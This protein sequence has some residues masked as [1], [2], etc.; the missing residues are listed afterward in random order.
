MM[1]RPASPQ[2]PI[3]VFGA[4]AQVLKMVP[5]I[6]GFALGSPTRFGRTQLATVPPQSE[7]E[8]ELPLTSF[9]VN[10]FPV[11]AVT[12]PASC[13]PPMILSAA[14]ERL[15]PIGFPL[16]KGSSYS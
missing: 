11:E 12:I 3:I 7:V 2:V 10:Q 9:G 13:H 16:P 1:L 8:T 15:P 4:K 14:P 6:Q 5:G